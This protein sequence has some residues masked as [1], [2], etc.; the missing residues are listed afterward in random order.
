MFIRINLWLKFFLGTFSII[1]INELT[2]HHNCSVFVKIDDFYANKDKTELEFFTPRLAHMQYLFVVYLMFYVIDRQLEYILRLDFLWS[3][4][5]KRERNEAKVTREVNQLLLKNILPIHVAQRYLFNSPDPLNED[6]YYEAYSSTAVM[7]AAIPN[8]FE[9]YK[10][11][12]KDDG[13]QYLATLNE[14]ICEFDR[15]IKSNHLLF[16]YSINSFNLLLVTYISSFQ[17]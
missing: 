3:T 16:N 12:T 7:F 11:S 15:V 4:K 6:L 10:E 13:L 1:I 8:F 14:I 17:S 9:Y 5:L 2:A